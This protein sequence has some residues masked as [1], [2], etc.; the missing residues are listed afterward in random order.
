[1]KFPMPI[2]D[3]VAQMGTIDAAAR[4]LGMARPTVSLWL[5]RGRQIFVM[6]RADGTM[7]FYEV[8]MAG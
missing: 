5:I 2:K 8:R 4:S 1:M 6:P 7:T 3:Y